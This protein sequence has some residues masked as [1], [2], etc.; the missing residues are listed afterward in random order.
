VFAA[1]CVAMAVAHFVAVEVLHV[2][3]V[4]LGTCGFAT[5]RVG[6]VISVLGM[7]VV[8]DVAVEVVGTVEPGTCADEGAAG[9]PLGT[10]V[11]VGS[12]VVGGDVIV[13][14]GAYRGGPDVDSD[15]SLGCGSGYRKLKAATEVVARILIGCMFHL[16]LFRQSRT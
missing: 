2:V 3:D 10:V 13:A 4:I 5:G 11:A 12:A 9:E 8:V 1:A 15:L 16:A 7:E 14:V 6:A